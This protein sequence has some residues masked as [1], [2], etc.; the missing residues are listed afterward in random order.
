VIA[1]EG[2]ELAGV[3]DDVYALVVRPEDI[4][5]RIDETFGAP[6]ARPGHSDSGL[7]PRKQRR[8]A[9]KGVREIRRALLLDL[10]SIGRGVAERASEYG[11]L[12]LP[13]RA[14]L[15]LPQLA[16]IAD[17]AAARLE[18]IARLAEDLDARAEWTFD[19][20]PTQ[21]GEGPTPVQKNA[22]A[23]RASAAGLRLAFSGAS[24]DVVAGFERLAAPH[25]RWLLVIRDVSPAASFH[26]QFMEGLD[27]FAAVSA[28]LFV[29]GDAFAALGELEIEER[30]GFGVDKIAVPSPFPYGDH[31][32]VAVL[33][34]PRDTDE[35]VAHTAEVLALLARQLGGR[36][37]GL[38]TSLRRM[39]EVADR[40]GA[41]LADDPIEVLAPRRAADDP[42]SLV[43]RFRALPGG[44]VLLGARTFWQ[45]LDIPGDDLQAVVIEKLPFEV[46]TELR[47]R[48]EARI[49][50]L[51]VN[52]F[53]RYRLGK[54][55]LH[56]KQM[57]GR[58]I[59]GEDDRGIV[60]IV[61]G[62][63]RRGYFE[64]VHDAFP[65]G[66]QLRSLEVDG[67]PG[68]LA[69]IGLGTLTDA[70]PAIRCPRPTS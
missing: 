25:D 64:R 42:A 21:S 60:V 15:Q 33:P 68:V 35:L 9:A 56:L 40:L 30:S 45:G 70:R 59:R 65:P 44:G 63:S 51:G 28:S 6:S 13:A 26:T 19:E 46:P 1:D 67:L 5:E 66:T 55:L 23:W 62:R 57:T 52:A 31:M 22:E 16:R 18:S 38:F 20:A 14:D 39:N 29:G 12:Q 11:E 32:R 58:L 2:H 49:A 54:M 37:L 47:R 7:L 50:E 43:R 27:S 24:D 17:M 53:E 69:E 61:E 41:E 10:T 36:T 3:A 8:E 48:R 34:D 4:L